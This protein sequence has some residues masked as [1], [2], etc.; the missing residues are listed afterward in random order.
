MAGRGQQFYRQI[1]REIKGQI[2]DLSN[3]YQERTAQEVRFYWNFLY[4]NEVDFLAEEEEVP[5]W[6][7]IWKPR[8]QSEIEDYI[9]KY[10][11]KYSLYD[12][13]EAIEPLELEDY[14]TDLEKPEYSGIPIE[15]IGQAEYLERIGSLRGNIFL[16]LEE[17][18]EYIQP[19]I[20]Y[21]LAIRK[22]KNGTYQVWV[23]N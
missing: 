2:S 3:F 15:E 10:I 20:G 4:L 5:N 11:E 13:T 18:L 16:D 8:L 21:V 1:K 6:L 9:E 14:D 19:F 17:L 12:E 23:S 7:S 22:R